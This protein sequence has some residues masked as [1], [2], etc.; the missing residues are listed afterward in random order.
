M[1]SQVKPFYT[2]EEDLDWEREA[3]YRSEYRDGT[4]IAMSGGTVVEPPPGHMDHD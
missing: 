1:A 2:F 3:A 4:I